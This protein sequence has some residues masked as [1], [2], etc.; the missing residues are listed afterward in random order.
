MLN[1]LLSNSDVAQLLGRSSI[2]IYRWRRDG[3]LPPPV[4]VNGR[5]IGWRQSDI[6]DWID[7]H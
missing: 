7:Q 4:M 2:T 5:S 6:S 3:I 1:P